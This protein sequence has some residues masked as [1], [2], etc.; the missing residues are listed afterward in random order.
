MKNTGKIFKNLAL[1]TQLG[2]QVMVPIALCVAAGVIIDNHFGTCWV[3]PLMIIGMLAG[4]RNAYRLAM[5]SAKDDEKEDS[6]NR[7]ATTPTHG[8]QR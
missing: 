3:I 4:G 2:L 1:I 5:A 8:R 6:D 7:D